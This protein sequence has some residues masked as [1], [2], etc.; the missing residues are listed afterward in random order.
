MASKM[1]YML[2]DHPTTAIITEEIFR[3]IL[4]EIQTSYF[5][6]LA[7]LLAADSFQADLLVSDLSMPGCTPLEVVQLTTSK[8]SAIPRIYFTGLQDDDV[9]SAISQ[10]NGLFLTKNAKYKTLIE[11]VQRYLQIQ[12]INTEYAAS[13]NNYQSYIHLPGTTKPLTI[14]QAKVMEQISKGFSGKEIAKILDMSPD[15]VNAHVKE[16]FQRLGVQNRIDAVERFNHAKTIALRLHGSLVDQ[17]L[18]PND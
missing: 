5:E 6:S 10:S 17:Q 14:K 2:E 15:T 7:D 18:Q 8:F 1:L 16:A 12:V 4:G 11:D 13:R 9:C 3:S